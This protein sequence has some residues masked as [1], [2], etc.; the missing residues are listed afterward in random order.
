MVIHNILLRYFC[1]DS[2]LLVQAVNLIFICGQREMST[3]NPK[4]LHLKDIM[5]ELVL[6]L[7]SRD[8]NNADIGVVFNRNRSTIKTIVDNNKPKRSK[9]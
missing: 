5:T 8:Y 3:K 1:L 2:I 9:R 7:H 4:K 6:Y